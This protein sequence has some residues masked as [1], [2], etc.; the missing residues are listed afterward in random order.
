MH[1]NDPLAWKL[2]EVYLPLAVLIG[3]LVLWRVW[4]K[5]VLNQVFAL[6]CITMV[7]PF[8]AADYTLVLLL[9]PMGFFLIFLLED[10]APGKTPM[11]MG[12]IL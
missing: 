3:V 10:V 11:S 5:P 2:Y 6:A 9:V 4:N 8:V 12:K 1:P 7:L